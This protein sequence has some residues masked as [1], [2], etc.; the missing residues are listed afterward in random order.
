MAQRVKNLQAMQE[1]WVWSLG[2]EDPLEKGMD[3]DSSILAWEIPWTEES[4]RI[5]SMEL[6]S[7]RHD[8]ATNTFTTTYTYIQWNITP[9]IKRNK[10]LSFAAIWVDLEPVIYSEVTQTEKEKCHII[11]I[12]WES[13]KILQMSLL[14][15]QKYSYKCRE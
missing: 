11:L 10:I 3:T 7:V 6:Q 1:T 13:R 15:K 9:V 2:W 4:G 14:A 8:W 12:M 5:Q